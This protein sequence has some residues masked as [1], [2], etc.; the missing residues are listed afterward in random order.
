MASSMARK[1]TPAIAGWRMSTAALKKR[2]DP[3]RPVSPWVI[4]F[5]LVFSGLALTWLYEPLWPIWGGVILVGLSFGILETAKDLR[6]MARQHPPSS[7]PRRSLPNVISIRVHGIQEP[8]V[9]ERE[10]IREI[11]KVPCRHCGAL[12]E[13]TSVRCPICDAPMT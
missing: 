12:I 5:V 13:N 6:T 1:M 4:C 2:K 9:R 7:L 11:V 8:V 10:I 3:I